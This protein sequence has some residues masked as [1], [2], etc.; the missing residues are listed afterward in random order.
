M[1]DLESFKKT[2][3]F[4]CLLNMFS[5]PSSEDTISTQECPSPEPVQEEPE[6][7]QEEQ[8]P[9]QEEPEPNH[10][11]SSTAPTPP[12]SLTPD[13]PNLDL[14]WGWGSPTDDVS[15][16]E[17]DPHEVVQKAQ[18]AVERAWARRTEESRYR[19]VI[20]L[21]VGF[22]SSDISESVDEC[23][24]HYDRLFRDLYNY[25]VRWFRIP[26]EKPQLS[27]GKVLM[28][29]ADED[30]HT[31][32]LIWYDGHGLEHRDR[33]GPPRW[34]ANTSEDSPTVDTSIISATLSDCEADIFI[35]NNSCQS[36][37]CERFNTKGVVEH[38]S[39]SAFSTFTYG[40]F[41][42][43]DQSPSLS[44]AAYRI[45]SDKKC[46]DDG[47]TVPEFHRRICLATQWGGSDKFP[48]TNWEDGYRGTW[49]DFK[50]RTEPV[51]TRLSADQA[52]PGGTTRT[53]VLR[54]LPEQPGENMTLICRPHLKLLLNVNEPIDIDSK[55]WVDWITSAPPN[56]NTAQLELFEDSE[57]AAWRPPTPISDTDEF[58]DAAGT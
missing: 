34:V 22:A 12:E 38:I 3:T 21:L 28:D 24:R 48:D 15:A 52:G 4:E 44:W 20:V 25:E 8:E 18:K 26:S 23:H 51:Y 16:V 5:H 7:I 36:L 10:A 58:E 41:D 9:I 6:P 39:A 2:L 57:G 42:G 46:V 17:L 11:N 47:I 33:R 40:S 50:C 54:R 37:N 14:S 35:M 30:S 55:A 13:T 19:R 1:A 56:V 27:F 32:L 45:L 49:V 29:L 31:L 43:T 53:I